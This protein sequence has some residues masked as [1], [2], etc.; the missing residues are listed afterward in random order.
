MPSMT[1]QSSP[2]RL[3]SAKS[4]RSPGRNRRLKTSANGHARAA[5]GVAAAEPPGGGLS[6]PL[7]SREFEVLS[8]L[9]NGLSCAEIGFHLAISPRT[10]WAH[11]GAIKRKLNAATAAHCVARGFE[12]KLLK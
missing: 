9:R 3:C 12:R 2:R 11:L 5:A 6:E 8:L 7:S 10:A 4:S 1:P